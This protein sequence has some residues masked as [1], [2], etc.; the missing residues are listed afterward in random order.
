ML[1]RRSLSIFAIALLGA[2][3]PASL[4]SAQATPVV[5]VVNPAK[6]FNEMQETLDLKQK[7]QGERGAIENEEKA[8]V[9]DVE[10]TRKAAGLFNPGTEEYKKKNREF[11]QKAIELQT[12]RELTKADLARQQKTQMKDL[13]TKI[14]T[15]TKEV[16]VAKKIDLVLV[17][18]RADLPEDLEQITVDQL[19]A[20]INQRTI[21]HADAKLDISGEVIAVLN[22]QYKNRK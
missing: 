22:A 18:Q 1:S 19:R 5:G 9:K 14:E 15:A 2:F 13:F 20:L 6:V 7:L 3:I 21:L 16:A 8:R 11:M 4:A 10:D 17:D 12:W